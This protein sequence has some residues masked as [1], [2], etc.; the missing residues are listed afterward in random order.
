MYLFNLDVFLKTVVILYSF[1]GPFYFERQKKAI[2]G[3]FSEHPMKDIDIQF[4]GCDK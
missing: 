2:S 4:I 1:K 3:I